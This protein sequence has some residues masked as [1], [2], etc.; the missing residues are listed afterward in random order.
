MAKRSP[1]RQPWTVR[2]EIPPGLE[3]LLADELR[4]MGVSEVTLDVGG[5]EARMDAA[6]LLRVQ[7][8]SRLASRATVRLAKV[9]APSLQGLAERIR[10]LPW[11][12]YIV[13]RQPIKVDVSTQRSRLRN[14][15]A[16]AA[17]VEHAIHDALR[18]PRRP[19][20]RPPHV[21]VTVGVRIVEDH[22]TVRVD[23][24]G[25][26]LHKRGWRKDP[27]RAPLRENLAVAVLRAAEWR[28]G[29]VLVDPMS[30][31]G[32]FGIEASLWS[33]G[34]A[35]GGKRNF[36]CEHWATWPAPKLRD[37][38]VAADP[39]SL[40][41]CA[42]RDV[43][44]VGRV[45]KNAN[46]AGVLNRIEVVESALEDLT[47]PGESG[48][49]VLNPPWGDRLGDSDHARTLHLRWKGILADRWPGFR[50]AVVVPDAPWA[51][52]AWSGS[53]RSVARFRSGGTA[54]SVWLR[55][56]S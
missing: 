23:A 41:L 24:S 42:D 55:T 46:R 16:V 5:V 43:R 54:V 13:P 44:S 27:G 22:A 32:T 53:Y 38:P 10:K 18:K 45:R 6:T 28:P 11:E 49:V 14:R 50:V 17:K 40:I 12:A 21:P 19:G 1:R 25:D 34:R 9:G 8:W 31:S 26:L 48:L 33:R 3:E 29:E 2:L 20:G 37:P 4:E 51:R 30:G 35:P 39:G 7:R 52:S 56:P 36:A 15:K 47:P